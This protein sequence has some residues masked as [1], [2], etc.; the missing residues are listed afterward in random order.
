VATNLEIR[1]QGEQFVVLTSP[2]LP[3]QPSFPNRQLISLMGLGAGLV[4]GLCLGIVAE[5]VDDRLRL[6]KEVTQIVAAP[7]LA[8]IPSMPT[9]SELRRQSRHRWLQWSA[10]A[11]LIS[12]MA[13][14]NLAVFLR[15]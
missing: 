14:G 6:D 9:L 12:V 15:G 13:I 10:A 7:V 5:L 1:Q 4:V 8:G 2:T 11:L 3:K